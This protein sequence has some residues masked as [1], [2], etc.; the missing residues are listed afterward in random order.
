[1]LLRYLGLVVRAAAVTQAATSLHSVGPRVC[2]VP[3]AKG[4]MQITASDRPTGVSYCTSTGPM[5]CTSV[6]FDV[7]ALLAQALLGGG[8]HT[9]LQLDGMALQQWAA[10]A[11]TAGRC[12]QLLKKEGSS[13]CAIARCCFQFE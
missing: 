13:K 3:L 10:K 9:L 1:M 4:R 6:R 2:F 11:V 5:S 12:P 7:L 8:G